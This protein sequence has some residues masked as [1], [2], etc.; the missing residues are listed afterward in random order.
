M[1]WLLAMVHTIRMGS[2]RYCPMA[3]AAKSSRRHC[4]RWCNYFEN[5]AMKAG[6]KLGLKMAQEIP[7]VCV[8]NLID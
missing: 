2:K 4:S 3:M 8:D 6:Y 7:A 1:A 5:A